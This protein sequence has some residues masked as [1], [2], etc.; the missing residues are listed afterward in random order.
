[1]PTLYPSHFDKKR[2]NIA[3]ELSSKINSPEGERVSSFIDFLRWGDS[4]DTLDV[5]AIMDG[6]GKIIDRGY[7]VDIAHTVFGVIATLDCVIENSGTDVLI[8]K[9]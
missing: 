4:I 9:E 8:T 6:L 5:D 3:F 1:M 7:D 2:L